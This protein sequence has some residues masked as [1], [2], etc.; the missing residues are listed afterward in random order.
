MRIDA[1]SK[2]TVRDHGLL[3]GAVGDIE[4][5][6]RTEAN[7]RDENDCMA[8]W[9]P[10]PELR[11]EVR[12]TLSLAGSL[13]VGSPAR[14]EMVEGELLAVQPGTCEVVNCATRGEGASTHAVV[15]RRIGSTVSSWG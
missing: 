5:P 2:D 7:V 14:N 9:Q 13:L 4:L 10:P 12:A 11:A 15:L 8:Y 3:V 1:S 6:L